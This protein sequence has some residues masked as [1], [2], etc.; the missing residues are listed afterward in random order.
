MYVLDVILVR[1]SVRVCFCILFPLLDGWNIHPLADS[2]SH[3]CAADLEDSGK[4][5]DLT[6]AIFKIL[7]ATADGFQPAEESD[8][9][10]T[11]TEATTVV[12]V[13]EEQQ[14]VTTST[15]GGEPEEE[16]QEETF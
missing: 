1:E 3:V 12:P 14:E 13:T 5:T 6:G 2:C 8:V 16:A 4:G 11:E 7:Y 9:T 15:S 10:E